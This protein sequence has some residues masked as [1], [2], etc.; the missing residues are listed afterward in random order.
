MRK[1]KFK[2]SGNEYTVDIKTFEDN[3]AEIEVNG[4][5]YFVELEKEIKTPKTPK[6]VRAQAPPPKEHKPL[7]STG[8]SVLKAPLPGTIL[9]VMAKPGD[10]VKKE[11]NLLVMEAMKMENNILSE[12]DGTI[13]SVK[14]A[15]GDTVLQGDVLLEIE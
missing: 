2:I 10:I 15:P 12:K 11:Q 6:L 8:V 5:Q 4:T 14:V 3:V 13:K 9:K 7:S 1:Y